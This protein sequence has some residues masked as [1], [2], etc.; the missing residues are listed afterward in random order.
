MSDGWSCMGR[1]EKRENEEDDGYKGEELGLGLLYT[2]IFF[3]FS[4]LMTKAC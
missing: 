2:L 4:I 3:F 1:G